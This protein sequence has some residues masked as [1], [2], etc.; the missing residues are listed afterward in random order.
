MQKKMLC[1]ARMFVKKR[2]NES[3]NLLHRTWFTTC[4]YLVLFANCFLI[5]LLP[6]QAIQIA[7]QWSKRLYG[8]ILLDTV[9]LCKLFSI[10]ILLIVFLPFLTA[11]NAQLLYFTST[12]YI[13][14]Y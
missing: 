10:E 1:D 8:I 2:M 6:A 12:P 3:I 13:M 5:V 9:L 7:F 4:E 11:I 14:H